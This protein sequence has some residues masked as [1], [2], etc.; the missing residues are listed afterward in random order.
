[1]IPISSA[2]S[3]GLTWTKPSCWSGSLE[4]RLNHEPVATL[5]RPS[6]WSASYVAE[7]QDGSWN[8]RRG[9]LLGTGAEIVDPVSNQPIATFKSGWGG[10]GTLA[11]TDGQ[12]F[13]VACKGW[14]H[15]LWTISTSSGQPVLYL[16]AWEKTVELPNA[17]VVAGN[18][19]SLLI[20]FAL[21]RV[22]Q[23]EEDAASAAVVAAVS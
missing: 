11:F 16:H 15:P 12:A 7:T 3:G 8:F 2:I 6:L 10:A 1:M 4:L 5:Q 14:W 13:H 17:S 21:Y 20:L 22:L 9:G 19:L 23:A 18:R